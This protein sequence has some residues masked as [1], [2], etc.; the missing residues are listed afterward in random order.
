MRGTASGRVV[1]LTFD[2]TRRRQVAS[3]RLERRPGKA[4]TQKQEHGGMGILGSE[5]KF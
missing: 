4:R 5:P 3:A 2:D 1:Q